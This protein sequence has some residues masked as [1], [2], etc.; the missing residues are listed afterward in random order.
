[1]AVGPR[2]LLAFWIGG[3]SGI[4]ETPPP[5]AVGETGAGMTPRRRV[6]RMPLSSPLEE[7]DAAEEEIELRLMGVLR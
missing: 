1:M 4:A 2:G 5:S 3:A 7:F 6:R